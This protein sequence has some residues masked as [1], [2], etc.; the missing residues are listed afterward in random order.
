MTAK[1]LIFFIAKISEKIKLSKNWKIIPKIYFI[2]KSIYSIKIYVLSFWSYII[3]ASLKKTLR[4]ISLW[5][6]PCWNNSIK[7]VLEGI[8]LCCFFFDGGREGR[9]RQFL[10]RS[11]FACFV[12]EKSIGLIKLK[13]KQNN[14]TD[15]LNIVLTHTPLRKLIENKNFSS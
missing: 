1:N 10:S 2:A 6:H 9:L 4:A 15:C 12:L 3:S 14:E 8:N 13:S 7:R 5:E 11:S